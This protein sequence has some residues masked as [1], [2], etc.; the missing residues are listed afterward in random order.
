MSLSNDELEVNKIP[1][2]V[3]CLTLL[4]Q[5]MGDSQQ[6]RVNSNLQNPNR[7]HQFSLGKQEAGAVLSVI[8]T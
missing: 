8:R 7:T 4:S 2:A 6:L 3:P 5:D 1:T